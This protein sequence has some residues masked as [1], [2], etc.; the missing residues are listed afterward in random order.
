MRLWYGE[1]ISEICV[2]PE[3][4]LGEEQADW[5]ALLDGHFTDCST[6]SPICSYVVGEKWLKRMKSVTPVGWYYYYQLGVMQY[7]AGDIDDAYSSF[8]HSVDIKKNAWSYRNIAMIEKNIKGN[9]ESAAEYILL[10]FKEASEYLPLIV[11]CAEILIRAEKPD[12]WIEI[13]N[14]LSDKLRFNG[15]LKML[16]G[17]AYARCGDISSARA[18]ITPDLVVDDIK[19]GEYALSSIWVEIYT[20]VLAKE[21]GVDA[22]SL[23][24]EDVLSFYPLPE[25]LDFR[26]H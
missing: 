9:L 8:L 18:M 16:L 21:R 12:L 4:S 13:Y 2:F 19:E 26:M 17:A 11:E 5:L 24:A 22:S 15:R 20:E 23:T 1:P 6:D 10:A 3:D 25:S 14:T 7:A